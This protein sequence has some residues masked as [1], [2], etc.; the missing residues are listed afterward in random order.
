MGLVAFMSDFGLRDPY[1]GVVHAV[2][3]KLGEGKVKIVDVSHEVPAFS[4]TAGAYI[5]YTSYKWFPRDTVFLVVVDPTVG[6]ERRP[7]AVRTRNYYFVGPDNGVL[8]QAMSEDGVVEAR[9]IENEDLF[10]KPVSKSFHGRDIFAPVAVHLAR[11]GGLE[12]VG[13]RIEA[14]SLVEHRIIDEC[15]GSSRLE[16]RVVYIDRFGNAALSLKGRS[17]WEKVCSRGRVL[18]RTHGLEV[19]A[20]CKEVFSL[21]KPGELVLY[22]NSFGFLE[23]AVNLGSAARELGLEIGSKTVIGQG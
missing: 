6:S 1:V 16:A 15:S 12:E 21:A 20:L 3:E 5:L 19:E 17:C 7:V 22:V 4:I 11:G 18:V 2:V 8:W 13:R 9:L 10:L 23:L 14:R